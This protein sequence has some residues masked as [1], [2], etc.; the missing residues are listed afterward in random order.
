MEELTIISDFF[1]ALSNNYR[2]LLILMLA[3]GEMRPTELQQYMG[4][5]APLL[6]KNLNILVKHNIV[7]KRR[8]GRENFYYLANNGF[9]K[10]IIKAVKNE[11]S[12]M[13]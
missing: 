5:K 10:E 11:M 1:K 3:D 2:L 9:I 6:S 4:I 7:R 13:S 8:A 12:E